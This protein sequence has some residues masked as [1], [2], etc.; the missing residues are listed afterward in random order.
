MPSQFDRAVSGQPLGSGE[1]E[2]S[3]EVTKLYLVY[4][5]AGLVPEVET[6]TELASALLDWKEDSVVRIA[7]RFNIPIEKMYEPISCLPSYE[8]VLPRDGQH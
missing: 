3:H 8:E 6:A 1:L 5:R 4:E 2:L 7:K